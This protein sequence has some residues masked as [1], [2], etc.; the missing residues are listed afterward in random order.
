M[1]IKC[2]IPEK[3]YH[4]V[5]FI[6]FHWF[7]YWSNYSVHYIKT[8]NSDVK[9]VLGDLT[10]I[11]RQNF[12]LMEKNQENIETA[13]LQNKEYQFYGKAFVCP[14]RREG[15]EFI[16]NGNQIIFNLDLIGTS[17]FWLSDFQSKFNKKYDRYHRI[18]A[19]N[20]VTKNYLKRP[21]VNEIFSF[22]IEYL[23]HKIRFSKRQLITF[24]IHPTHDV[25]HPFL[26]YKLPFKYLMKN[27]LGD[28]VLRKQNPFKRIYHWCFMHDMNKDKYNTFDWLL[29]KEK[30]L[31][32]T[33]YFF[34]GNSQFNNPDYNIKSEKIKILIDKIN[35][36]E[37]TIGI[38]FGL[39]TSVDNI[40]MID[41]LKRF[42]RV[43]GDVSHSRFHY[44]SF[45][46][47]DTIVNL[48]DAII[49]ND[50][51]LA[52]PDLAGFRTGCCYPHYLYN[53]KTNQMSNMIENPLIF[54]EGTI[55][56]KDNENRSFEDAA[57]E[58]LY[59]KEVV[60][61]HA[62]EF[63][64]LWHNHRLIKKEEKDLFLE[65]IR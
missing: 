4:E 26:H 64:F 29:E 32:S 23:K 49:S 50:S 28:V 36:N 47:P 19:S 57:N 30:D 35:K 7:E 44:L 61:K 18:Y 52:F 45:K 54:M 34:A 12:F 41:E 20:S 10:L 31:D 22:L 6:V 59:F 51:T 37:K 63:T 11:F 1:Q 38:H 55:L 2:Y 56:D 15:T 40:K 60:K 21:V 43:A 25:D 16:D 24:K 9:I 62:G 46:N 53:F 14:F 27:S 8:Q 17:F 42:Q 5:K 58:M 33:Y 13:L 48:E 65:V 3:Y 39:G